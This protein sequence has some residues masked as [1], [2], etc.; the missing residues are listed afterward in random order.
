KAF[1]LV[2]LSLL[3]LAI[4]KIKL[5]NKVVKMVLNLFERKK[6]RVIIAIGTTDPYEAT[7]R[8]NQ[9]EVL[10]SLLW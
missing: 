2:S 7:N 4:Y 3:E 9:E 6:I 10:S 8:V 1:N 5:P